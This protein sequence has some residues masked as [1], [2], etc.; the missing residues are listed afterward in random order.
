MVFYQGG[1]GGMPLVTVQLSPSLHTAGDAAA[2]LLPVCTHTVVT[3]GQPGLQVQRSAA[4]GVATQQ[5]I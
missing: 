2:A 4:S 3:P 5:R 1:A